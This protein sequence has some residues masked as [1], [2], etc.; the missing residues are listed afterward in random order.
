MKKFNQPS[1]ERSIHTGF[2]MAERYHLSKALAT[3]R[4]C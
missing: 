1:F 3:A 4:L 2:F